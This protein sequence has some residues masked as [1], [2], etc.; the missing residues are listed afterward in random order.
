MRICE[1]REKTVNL[2]EF[3]NIFEGKSVQLLEILHDKMQF[4]IS[5]IST[6]LNVKFSC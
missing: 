2:F 4:K 6:S 5:Q 3:Y 1:E